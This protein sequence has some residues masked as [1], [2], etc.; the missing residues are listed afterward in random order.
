MKGNEK[1]KETDI[2]NRT[3]YHFD[4]IIEIKDFDVD[5]ILKDEKKT[6]KKNKYILVYKISYKSLF[7]SKPLRI[8]FDK[9]NRFIK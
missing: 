2:E 8:R 6:K 9:R 7:N 4:D 3:C 1:L 5:N